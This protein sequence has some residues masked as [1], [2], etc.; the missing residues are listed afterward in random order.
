MIYTNK[1]N[2][3]KQLT[4]ITFLHDILHVNIMILNDAP[5]LAFDSNLH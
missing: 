5:I 2:K 1:H 4:Q 3:I